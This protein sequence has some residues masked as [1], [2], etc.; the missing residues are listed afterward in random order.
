MEKLFIRS[1]TAVALV[2]LTVGL[3]IPGF[4]QTDTVKKP[5][6]KPEPT[7]VAAKVK[8]APKITTADQVAESAI[9]LYGFPGGR[10][11]L[12][13]IRKT[14]LERGKSTITGAD[15]LVA[16]ASYQRFVIRA[17]TLAK[18][19]IRLDQDFP[20]AK[21]SLIFDDGKIY[22]IYNNTVFTPREDAS[23]TF[24]N[25]IVHGIEALLRY[26]ENESRLELAEREKIMGVDYYVVD[27]TDK[28]ERKTRFYVSVKSFRVMMLTYEDAGVK[29]RRK[30]YDFN[31]AQGTLVPYRTVLWAND[32]IVEETELGTITFGQKVDEGLFKVS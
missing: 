15:G 20:N 19:R 32:K 21:Y 5:A 13:Q 2:V 30:F 1:R 25:Q 3:S 24:E 26:K 28:Q 17:E 7:P 12:N 14:T 22:G 16:Q 27:L 31:Y 9:F 10:A 11:T 23:K 8:G 18:E 29:F 6:N 4:S